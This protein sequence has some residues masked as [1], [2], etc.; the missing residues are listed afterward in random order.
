LVTPHHEAE[1]AQME[2]ASGRSP[3]VNYWMHTGFLNIDHK[4]MSKSL[5][6]FRT[7]REALATIHYTTLRYFFLSHHYR[8]VMDLSDESLE[9]A[10]NGL[11]RIRT[12]ARTTEP[13][14]DDVAN[15]DSVEQVR[16]ALV[17]ALD[18]DFD[19]PNALAVLFEFIRDQNRR[20]A[21]GRRVAALL[22]DFNQIFDVI[23]TPVT[24][25]DEEV[26]RQL[27]RRRELRGQGRYADADAVRD[28]LAA[29][30]II[31]EDTIEGAKWRR[32]Y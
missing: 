17:A 30:G 5:G 18:N 28:Q 20:G 22:T 24:I 3:L 6:N 9:G 13:A 8:Q 25:I 16:S 23:P 10:R 26:E 4:K 12:F 11:E 1:I 7:I 21:P 29:D 27:A 19:T 15:E 14:F 31:L 32:R 2:A